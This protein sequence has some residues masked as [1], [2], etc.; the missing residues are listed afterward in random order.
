MKTTIHLTP[1]NSAFVA[2]HLASS[3]AGSAEE[4]VNRMLTNAAANERR[5]KDLRSEIAVGIKQADAGELTDL[6]DL[7]VETEVARLDDLDRNWQ[8]VCV[9]HCARHT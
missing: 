3:E 7:D 2:E 5:L 1:Q 9:A 8:T 4:F 6:N